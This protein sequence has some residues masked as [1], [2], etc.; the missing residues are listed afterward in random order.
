M[1][2]RAGAF[3]PVGEEEVRTAGAAKIHDMDVARLQSGGEELG[4]IGFAEVE[5]DVFRRRLVAGRGHVEPLERIRF[6]SGPKLIEIGGGVGELGEELGGDFG[7]DFVAAGADAGADGGYE[8]ARVGGEV[9]LH[10]TNGFGD[11]AGERAAP[12]G[13]NGGDGALFRVDQEDRNAVS[14]LHGEEEARTIGHQSITAAGFG[15]CGLEDVNHVG[16]D[17]LQRDEWKIGGAEGG[18]EAAAVFETVFAGVPVGEAEVEDFFT[19][20]AGHAARP[21][22]ETMN[23]PRQF[24]KGGDLKELD[25]VRRRTSS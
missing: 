7:A 11:D 24:G 19:V 18:L 4:A 25:P 20:E 3:F 22:A 13:V 23:E 8:V 15:G 21:C 9:H 2:T 16:V 6:V 14:G 10:G 1:A 17:L 5:E 12:T